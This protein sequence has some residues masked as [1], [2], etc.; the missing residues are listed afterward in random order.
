MTS[1]ITMIALLTL[2]SGLLMFFLSLPLCARL[3]R[4]LHRLCG[5]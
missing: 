4:H 2:V 3:R 5:A 1:P